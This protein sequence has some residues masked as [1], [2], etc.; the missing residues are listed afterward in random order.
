MVVLVLL[1]FFP[2]HPESHRSPMCRVCAKNVYE[3]LSKIYLGATY[4]LWDLRGRSWGP[5]HLGWHVRMPKVDL[6]RLEH[7]PTMRWTSAG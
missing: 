1:S 7:S 4:P 2:L 5:A 6:A 3:R